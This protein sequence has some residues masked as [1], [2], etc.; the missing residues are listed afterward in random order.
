MYL[1][2][3]K[4]K[5]INKLAKNNKIENNEYLKT[6]RNEPETKPLPELIKNF[7]TWSRSGAKGIKY[8]VKF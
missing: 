1:E 4:E 8:T 5:L 3:L 2:I 7:D 6:K